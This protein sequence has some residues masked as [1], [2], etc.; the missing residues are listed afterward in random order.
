MTMPVNTQTITIR[1]TYKE[2]FA[3]LADPANLP[4]WVGGF[5]CSIARAG[6]DWV[7][8]TAQGDLPLRCVADAARGTM[9]LYLTVAPGLDVAAA[10]RLAANGEGTE[11]I[12][13][14]FQAPACQTRR[15]RCSGPHSATSWRS[16]PS[17]FVPA[18]PA[19]LAADG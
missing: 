16:C 12:F 3:F 9:D 17:S 14:Q 19:R 11:H 8:T 18:R 13:S 10:S 2:A 15:S 1:A 6:D 5:A 4:R 7:V